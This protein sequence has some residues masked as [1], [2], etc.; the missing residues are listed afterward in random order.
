MAYVRVI[1]HVLIAKGTKLYNRSTLIAQRDLFLVCA[2]TARRKHDTSTRTSWIKAKQG[3]SGTGSKKKCSA[4]RK[5][6]HTD[7]DC[8][9][10]HPA[11]APQ[12]FKDTTKE[13]KTARSSVEV[14]LAS[15]DVLNDNEQDFTHT[16]LME[17]WG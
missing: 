10:K 17:H 1:H 13:G 15:V 5:S 6:R 9:K 11:K 2:D 14:V 7:V 3:G 8:W 16:C 4:C 12:W